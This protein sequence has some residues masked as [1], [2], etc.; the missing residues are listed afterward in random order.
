MSE[1][2]THDSLKPLISTLPDREREGYFEWRRIA[3]ASS[4]AT[5]ALRGGRFD[6]FSPEFVAECLQKLLALHA[7]VDKRLAMLSGD[8]YMDSNQPKHKDSA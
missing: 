5:R 4:R 3:S 6:Y 2:L 7:E 1:K 8:A